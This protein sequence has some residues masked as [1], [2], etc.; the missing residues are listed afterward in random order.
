MKLLKLL[1]S[2]VCSAALGTLVGNAGAAATITVTPAAIPNTYSGPLSVQLTG[3]PNGA[4]VRVEVLHDFN[5]NNAVD[6]GDVLLKRFT[7][8][9][10]TIPTIG[11]RT[12]SNV[13]ADLDGAANGALNVTLDYRNTSAMDHVAGSYILRLSSPTS[14]F[15]AV[16]TSLTVTNAAFP[17]NVTGTVVGAS[18]CVVVLVDPLKPANVIVGTTAAANGSYTL[19]CPIGQ[20][21]LLAFQA[22][23]VTD[24][25][26]APSVNVGATQTIPL[27]F[28]FLNPDRT[29]TGLLLDGPGGAPLP[30]VQVLGI[31][32]GQKMVLGFTDAAGAF[33]LA[34]SSDTWNLEFS[35]ADL[36]KLGCLALSQPP[37]IDA[38]AAPVPATNFEM[39][40]ATSLIFGRITDD[41][42]LPV[43]GAYITGLDINN[44]LYTTFATTDA[45]GN[46]TLGVAEGMWFTEPRADR[47]SQLGYLG[48][49]AV[50]NA[51]TATATAQDFLLRAVTATAQGLLIDD[52]GA[53]VPGM[54]LYALDTVFNIHKQV[55]S[56]PDG[57]FSLGLF[58][59]TWSVSFDDFAAQQAG[60]IAP[61]INLVV[62]DG[63]N[64]PG[65]IYVFPR[66]TA[67]ISGIVTNAAG[68]PVS[69][70][71]VTANLTAGATNYQT[72]GFTVEDGTY[73][74]RVSAGA[75]QFSLNDLSYLGYANPAPQDQAIT[76]DAVINWSV[77]AAPPAPPTLVITRVSAGHYQLTL[78]GEAGR[79]YT[80][81]SAT[82]LRN[83]TW[84]P[85]I[86]NTADANG[87]LV[88]DDTPVA[89]GL[90]RF[91]RVRVVP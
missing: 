68:L 29:L 55:L 60:I 54:T 66:T 82:V 69:S 1:R 72:S 23:S 36:A 81:E 39:L 59:S 5:G 45:N 80:I 2:F 78:T 62:Q 86:T 57:S 18:N 88:Q 84:A 22:G 87:R 26:N 10:G 35:A 17:Q 85:V 37:P 31:S 79:N 77:A 71:Y 41:S 47:L 83:P 75:W 15:A 56:G 16:T 51:V 38:T 70:T 44:Y 33:S 4:T 11:G 9:D 61:R 65:I 43:V 89:D 63:V 19:P 27:D 73:A 20:F 13:P 91:Y 90:P 3:V 52:S 32:S 49:S 14:A 30:G 42:N 58:G 53:P 24:M 6:A 34:A 7:L 67:T 12:N 28:A 8:T 64:Q 21:K 25:A 74:F 76:D 46:Y 48:R 50:A 40:R